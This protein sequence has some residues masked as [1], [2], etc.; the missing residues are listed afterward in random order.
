MYRHSVKMSK[1]M[2]KFK[3][4][5]KVLATYQPST[6]RIL[7]ER[8]PQEFIRAIID[9]AWTTLTVKLKL[10]QK[11]IDDIRAVQPALRRIASRGQTLDDRRTLLATPSGI[12]AVRVY[13]KVISNDEK[14]HT[15]PRSK[16]S[17]DDED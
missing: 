9:A 4:E 1:R 10:T 14:V 16:T 17:A 6:A 12:K 8:A 13:C 15:C 2:S 3:S 11:D 7:F 5:L